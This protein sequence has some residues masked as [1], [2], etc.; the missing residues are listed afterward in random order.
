MWA[1]V[2]DGVVVAYPYGLAELRRDRPNTSFPDSMSEERLAEHGILPVLSQNPPWH[3]PLT[4]NCT[5]VWPTRSEAG[6]VETWSV[7]T[8]SPEDIAARTSAKAAEVRARRNDLLAQS[9]WT[10]V[11]DAPVNK[12]AW[13]TYRQAL[14]DITAA[15]GFPGNVDWPSAP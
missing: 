12:E 5:R 10:Q 7:T 11:A 3:D 14:R 15:P 2:Q 8:A 4:Q 9:D 6:W 13:A 1:K